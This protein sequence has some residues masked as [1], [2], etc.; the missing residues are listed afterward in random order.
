[1]ARDAKAVTKNMQ[2]KFS[3]NV[4]ETE[5]DI[6]RHLLDAVVFAHCTN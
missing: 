4:G 5:Q 6:L 1:M 3:R 2:Q